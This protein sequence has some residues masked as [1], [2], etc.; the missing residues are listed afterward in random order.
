MIEA[1][2]PTSEAFDSSCL[3]RCEDELGGGV[4]GGDLLSNL[5]SFSTLGERGGFG[6]V[7]VEE[8]WDSSTLGS[9]GGSLVNGGGFIR[10]AEES[11]IGKGCMGGTCSVSGIEKQKDNERFRNAKK[12]L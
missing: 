3:S 7:G 9:T 5:S 12:G 11:S 1:A 8:F 4:L 6:V 10:F 2:S